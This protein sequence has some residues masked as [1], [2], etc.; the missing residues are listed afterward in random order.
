MDDGANDM[1]D[2]PDAFITSVSESESEEA[3]EDSKDAETEAGRSTR[4]GTQ[5]NK[6]LLD[7][8]KRREKLEKVSDDVKV[9]VLQ[10]VQIVKSIICHVQ[11]SNL[12]MEP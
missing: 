10:V 2:D 6:S 7:A 1:D 9:W 5:H 3:S 12:E 8:K 4:K 11:P